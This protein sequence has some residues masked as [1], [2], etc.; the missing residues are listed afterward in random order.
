MQHQVRILTSA[1]YTSRGL[2]KESTEKLGLYITDFYI[3]CEGRQ[4]GIDES[5]FRQNYNRSRDIDKRYEISICFI[6][7]RA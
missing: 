5:T 1:Y 6:N 2:N 7:N 4:D 3:N